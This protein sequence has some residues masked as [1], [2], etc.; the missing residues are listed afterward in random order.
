MTLSTEQKH[1]D[2]Y[3][4]ATELRVAENTDEFQKCFVNVAKLLEICRKTLSYCF[5]SVLSVQCGPSLRC[6]VLPAANIV[7]YS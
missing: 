5:I 3:R 6:Q 7:L 4:P 2:V 1:F